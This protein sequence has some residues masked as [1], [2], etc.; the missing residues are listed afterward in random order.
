MSKKKEKEAPVEPVVNEKTE[1][2]EGNEPDVSG[3]GD[4]EAKYAAGDEPEGKYSASS[5]ALT[6]ENKEKPAKAK[7]E[8]HPDGPEVLTGNKVFKGNVAIKGQLSVISADG[9]SSIMISAGRELA[10][11]WVQSESEK[12]KYPRSSIA[13]YDGVDGPV[14]GFYRDTGEANLE[15]TC[16]ICIGQDGNPQI[17]V[18][19]GKGGFGFI[20]LTELLDL[21][22]KEWR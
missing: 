15:M 20:G 10:G 21:T 5:L 12:D 13:I 3:P 14:L 4:G 18:P 17:Q 1:E 9:K 11:I 16:A 19:N 2:E 7:D 8:L 22:K 6:S